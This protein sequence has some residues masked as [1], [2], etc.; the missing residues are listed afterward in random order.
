M[1]IIGINGFK[2]SG[3]GETGNAVA[4]LLPNVHQLGFADKLKIYAARSL[5]YVENTDAENIALMDRAKE[6]WV[7]DVKLRGHVIAPAV[8][9][10]RDVKSWTVRSL[11]QY[12]GTEARTVF[13][14]DFWVDQVLP[15][16]AP[17]SI[18]DDI[19]LGDMYPEADTLVF[20]DLR[21]PNEAERI[22]DLG[23]FVIEVLRPTATSD[24][25]ASELKLPSNLV[26]YQIGND[27]DL[28]TL[29]WKVNKVLE[30]EG[31]MT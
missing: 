17:S 18:T 4:A 20:T 15:A 1:N 27:S 21:F 3:K 14:D 29:G 8:V 19:N 28:A 30:L 2:R 25:H 11:L 22:I 31:L 6:N 9:G 5:G 26:K 13:G 24:G 23:G 16:P 10:G 7:L 12:M